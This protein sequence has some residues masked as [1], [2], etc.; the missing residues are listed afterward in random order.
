MA[1]PVSPQQTRRHV[2]ALYAQYFLNALAGDLPD[3]AVMYFL[4]A[5]DFAVN[6]IAVIVAVMQLPWLLGVVFGYASDLL[7]RRKAVVLTAQFLGVV[8]WSCLALQTPS[9]SYIVPVLLVAAEACVSAWS[10]VDDAILVSY[11]L[12]ETNDETSNL[13]QS[14]TSVFA[15]MGRIAGLL[16]GGYVQKYMSLAWICA[17]Q[18]LVLSASA[19]GVTRL[20]EP[21]FVVGADAGQPS[22][23]SD[24]KTLMKKQPVRDMAAIIFLLLALPGQRVVFFYFLTGPRGFEA[25]DIG[26]LDALGCVLVALGTFCYPRWLNRIPLRTFYVSLACALSLF[27]VMRLL[28]VERWNVFAGVPDG[29]MVLALPLTTGVINLAF[30]PYGLAVTAACPQTNVGT[31]YTAAMYLPTT[32]MIMAYLGEI[33]LITVYDVNHGNYQGLASLFTVILATSLLPLCLLPMLS[34]RAPAATVSPEAND[35]V[36]HNHARSLGRTGD[37]ENVAH[38]PPKEAHDWVAR[39]HRGKAV[40]D[41]SVPRELERLESDLVG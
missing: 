28:V 23:F 29:L 1:H 10:A 15:M 30:A 25:T 27:V 11:V 5:C 20:S 12:T 33:R 35:A 22:V 19:L 8:V 26:F 40:E 13:V 9:P 37:A 21:D 36:A 7:R 18:S 17:L 38:T 39:Q 31:V 4:K 16:L 3:I 14:N 2:S 41:S 6:D 34:F 24:V 32:A